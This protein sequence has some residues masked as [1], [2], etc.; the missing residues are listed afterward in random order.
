MFLPAQGDIFLAVHV[1]QVS[2]RLMALGEIELKP[3]FK[4]VGIGFTFSLRL[5]L[6]LLTGFTSRDSDSDLV[7]SNGR[8]SLQIIMTCLCRVP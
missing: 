3:F 5:W 7:W 8:N 6:R 2:P 4:F 1:F